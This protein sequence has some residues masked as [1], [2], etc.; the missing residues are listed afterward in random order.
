MTFD[1]NSARYSASRLSL[2]VLVV[3]ILISFEVLVLPEAEN[4]AS[5]AHQQAVK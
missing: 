2:S 4:F 5:H 3:A 1:L